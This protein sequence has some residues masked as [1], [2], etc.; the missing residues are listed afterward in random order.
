M[1][2]LDDDKLNAVLRPKV[3]GGWLLHKLT[4][5]MPLDFF[6]L[7]SSF[8]SILSSPR[9][10]HYAAANSFLDALA[11]Y[12]RSQGLPALSINWGAWGD[13]GMATRFIAS[14]RQAL[15]GLRGFSTTEALEILGNLMRQD[16][17]QVGVMRIDWDMWR[18]LYPSFTRSPML[19]C[20][21]DALASPDFMQ[22]KT[23]AI[24]DL[25][26]GSQPHDRKTILEDYLRDLVAKSLRMSAAKISTQ[27]PLNNLGIDS[28]TAIE[29]KR[30][31]ESDLGVIVPVVSLLQGPSIA[32]LAQQLLDEMKTAVGVESELK[33]GDDDGRKAVIDQ[34]SEQQ[35]DA[36]LRE[37]LIRG[38]KDQSEGVNLQ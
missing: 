1:L 20:I 2:E 9:L 35:V 26:S 33:P 30:R 15:E 24:R 19:S 12:R 23:S 11:H 7:F 29:V 38:K 3:N 5:D 28:L 32:Q 34:L 36:L 16:R 8:S 21:T 13:I 6:V 17:A 10:G 25:I 22:A 14:G 37:M 4:A 18:S 27:Q 31:V